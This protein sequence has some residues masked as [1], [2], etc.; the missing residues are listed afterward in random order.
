MT[1][2]LPAPAPT[3]D[4][5]NRKDL[6]DWLTEWR[7]W[8]GG[9]VILSALWAARCAQREELSHY[10]PVTPLGV[11]AAVLIALAIWPRGSD[12]TED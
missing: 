2:D 3:R 10:W 8:L 11:W 9:A 7:Y 5:R 4:D 1:A 12:G 6:H